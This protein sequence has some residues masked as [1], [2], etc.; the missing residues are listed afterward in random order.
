MNIEG[1]EQEDVIDAIA[2]PESSEALELLEL[3]FAQLNGDRE[4]SATLIKN[5]LSCAQMLYDAKRYEDVVSWLDVIATNLS[6]EKGPDSEVYMEF[7][8]SEELEELK[9]KATD[10]IFGDEEEVDDDFDDE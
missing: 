5:A 8:E 4:D 1:I 2:D 9:L 7:A 3:Y 6:D 10:K